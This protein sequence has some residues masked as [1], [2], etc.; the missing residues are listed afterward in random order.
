MIKL[1]AIYD[2]PD[3]EAAF[4]EH[5]EGVHAP[6]TRRLPGL[7]DLELLRITADAFGGEPPHY[8]MAIMTFPDKETFKTAMRSEENKRVAEDV[9][10]FAK[11]K[12]RVL[13]SEVKEA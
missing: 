13:V 12:V 7:Q 11:G 10:S 3:D 2:K 4:W 9:M 6:L 8:L 1:I 5:Y